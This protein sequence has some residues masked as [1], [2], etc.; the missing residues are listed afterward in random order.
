MN[1]KQLL[2]SLIEEGKSTLD[3]EYAFNE[4]CGWLIVE[5]QWGPGYPLEEAESIAASILL[6]QLGELPWE[7]IYDTNGESI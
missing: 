1:R 5:D 4:M 7:K 6:N 3:T 2:F